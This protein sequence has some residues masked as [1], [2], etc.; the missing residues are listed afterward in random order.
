MTSTEVSQDTRVMPR[1]MYRV[2]WDPDLAG[3]RGHCLELPL[4]PGGEAH[5][6]EAAALEDVQQRAAAYVEQ[7]VQ[8]HRP[9]PPA[10]AESTFTGR[11]R[12]RILPEVHRE[13]AIEAAE[14][15]MSLTTYISQILASRHSRVHY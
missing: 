11:P 1:Y 8:Q 2:L 3:W 4:L 9:V 10:S 14:V 5:A 13:L 7:L 15:G 12:V 6:T